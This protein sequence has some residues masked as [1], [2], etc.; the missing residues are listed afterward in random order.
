MFAPKRHLYADRAV[1]G[2]YTYNRKALDQLLTDVRNGLIDVVVV[3]DLDRLSRDLGDLGR[4]FRT[5]ESRNVE[6]HAATRGKCGIMEVTMVGYL[7]MEQRLKVTTITTQG[8]W[9][10]AA[11]GRNPTQI[12]YGY[13]RSALGPGIIE[14]EPETAKIVRRIFDLADK[15]V[16]PGTIATLL[17]KEGVKSPKGRL[18]SRSCLVGESKRWLGILRNTKYAGLSIYGRIE[19]RRDPDDGTVTMTVRHPSRWIICEN[20][21][22]ALVDPDQWFRVHGRLITTICTKVRG[23]GNRGEFVFKGVTFCTC[24]APMYGSF[25]RKDRARILFCSAAR[26]GGCNNKRT[27]TAHFM[28]REMLRIVRDVIAAPEASAL[29]ETEYLARRDHV[30][31]KV[32]ADRTR[33]ESAIAL[34]ERKLERTFDEDHSRALS[35]DRI[36]KLQT[37]LEKELGELELELQNLPDLEE[38]PKL[39]DGI[40][41]DFRDAV[42]KLIGRLPIEKV[43]SSDM[44]LFQAL[45][46]V[47]RRVVVKMKPNGGYVLKID[48]HL[49]GLLGSSSTGVSPTRRLVRT[50]PPP[51]RGFMGDTD[52]RTMFE[53]IADTG[54]YD[55][56]EEDWLVAEPLLGTRRKDAIPQRTV[57]N[58]ALFHARTRVPLNVLPPRYG[59]P[60]GISRAVRIVLRSGALQRTLEALGSRGSKAVD[61]LDHSVFERRLKDGR[62]NRNVR[63][64]VRGKT[65]A[66]RVAPSRNRRR[67]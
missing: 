36:S 55:V 44:V 29:F 30:T 64:P 17:N 9:L 57:L 39:P 48:G 47:V 10:A 8:R 59:T 11:D 23:P 51:G 46:A 22:I 43:G 27:V 31:R 19:T 60:H 34:L 40:V 28:E 58:A 1:S 66:S 26:R 6:L 25:L 50:C 18:W 52:R 16:S 20:G 62:A 12:P 61:G 54:S 13:R 41:A 14:E 63:R 5:L 7:S 45:R 21:K 53:T 35:P 65:S 24:G 4:M 67:A 42:E 56:S 15:G 37:R 33:L 49:A 32:V 3:E 38:M 2:A